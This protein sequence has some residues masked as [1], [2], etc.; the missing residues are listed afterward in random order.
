MKTVLAISLILLIVFT[1]TSVKFAA[2]YCQ[3][4]VA[5]TKVSLTGELATCGMESQSGN[6]PFQNTFRK[7][8]CDDV[9]SS[10]SICNNY[11]SSS[12]FIIYPWQKVISVIDIPVDCIGNQVLISLISDE[13]I[14]PPG[15]CYPGGADQ[16]ALCV[17]RL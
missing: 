1:G 4:S 11:F 6:T 9:T 14:R 16:P 2:H 13:I 8:C 17:F 12:H 10:Y 5:A 7:H 15:N 3:G